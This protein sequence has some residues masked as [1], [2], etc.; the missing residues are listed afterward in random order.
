MEPSGPV[1]ACI[2]ITLNFI[3]G[4]KILGSNLGRTREFYILQNVQY[5]SGPKQPHVKRAASFFPGGTA[6]GG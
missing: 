1:Q 2:G 4:W 3:K 5:G 6:A